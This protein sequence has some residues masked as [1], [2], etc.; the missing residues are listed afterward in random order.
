MS[1]FDFEA[2]PASGPARAAVS[3]S[4]TWP[5]ASASGGP[6]KPGR[7]AVRRGRRS[8]S[9]SYMACGLCQRTVGG[10]SDLASQDLSTQLRFSCTYNNG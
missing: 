7:Q 5:T 4:L 10:T 1:I 9:V 2:R 3:F 8:V 6:F